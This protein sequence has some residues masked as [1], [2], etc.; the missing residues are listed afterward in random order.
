[1]NADR[2]LGTRDAGPLRKLAIP[3]EKRGGWA[4]E[5]D[6]VRSIRDAQPVRLTDFETGVGYM[7]FTE[8]VARSALNDELIDLPLEE[9][10]R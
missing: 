6:F 8:A 2:I 4:A 3:N 9:F 10:T 5:T 7:E 1:M